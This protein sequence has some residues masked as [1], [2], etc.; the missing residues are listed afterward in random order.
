MWWLDMISQTVIFLTG[1]TAL[2]LLARKNKWGWVVGL[3]GSPFWF[4]TTAIHGQGLLLLLNVV[5]TVNWMYG[6]YQWFF[7]K[8]S[9][10]LPLVVSEVTE[11]ERGDCNLAVMQS[12]GPEVG[13]FK[14][15]IL[16]QLKP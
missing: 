8:Q 2:I 1:A 4:I 10:P 11:R 9:Q 7:K 15:P 14:H 16:S 5:Y 12:H 13:N 6:F 3:I